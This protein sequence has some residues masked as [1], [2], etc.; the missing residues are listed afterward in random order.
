MK[1]ASASRI[2]AAALVLGLAACHAPEPASTAKTV[3]K[4]KLLPYEGRVLLAGRDLVWLLSADGLFLQDTR[5]SQRLAINLPDWQWA[6][7]PYACMPDLTLGPKGEVIVTSN[8]LPKLWRVDPETLAVTV[9]ALELDADNG[10][11]VG[12]AGLVYSPV[13]P[14]YFAVSQLHGSLWMIDPALRRASKIALEDLADSSAEVE[15]AF[16]RAACPSTAPRS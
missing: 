11:D 12:F 7:E 9:H 13:S 3:T 1:T 14:A 4:Q 10:K 16:I 5:T 8:I 15:T 6:G 2:L